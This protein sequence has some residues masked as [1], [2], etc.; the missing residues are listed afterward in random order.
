MTITAISLNKMQVGKKYR[1]ISIAEDSLDANLIRDCWDQGFLP[2]ADISLLKSYPSQSKI[3]VR[4]GNEIIIALPFSIAE[5]I[6]VENAQ[7]Q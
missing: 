3:V 4:I 6:Q 7:L 1:I 5:K 2:G